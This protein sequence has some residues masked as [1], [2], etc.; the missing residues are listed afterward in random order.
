MSELEHEPIEPAEHDDGDDWVYEIR[1]YP[2]RRF[3][4]YVLI[5][6]HHDVCRTWR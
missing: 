3:R 1:F 6:C 5:A 2:N 4:K